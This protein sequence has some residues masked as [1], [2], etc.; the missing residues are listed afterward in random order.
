M[1]KKPYSKRKTSSFI[2]NVVEDVENN[3]DDIMISPIRKAIK[4]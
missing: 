2:D 3:Q 1:K 4:F